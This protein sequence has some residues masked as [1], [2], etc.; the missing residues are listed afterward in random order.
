MKRDQ[1][2]SKK[3]MSVLIRHFISALIND[4]VVFVFL[5]MPF[6]DAPS[7]WLRQSADDEHQ[8][9]GKS[10]VAAMNQ[11]PPQEFWDAHAERSA[12]GLETISVNKLLFSIFL[13]NAHSGFTCRKIYS[14]FAHNERMSNAIIGNRASAQSL[15]M[16]LFAN[17]FKAS[18]NLLTTNAIYINA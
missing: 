2:N 18:A 13:P 14:E 7:S 15:S 11:I 9:S 3:M 17:P 10:I 1:H 5:L 6:A 8:R 12:N 4:S 16:H